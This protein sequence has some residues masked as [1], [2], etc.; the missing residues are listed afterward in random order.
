MA[1]NYVYV[2]VIFTLQKDYD[3][4]K[5]QHESSLK[6]AEVKLRT[7]LQQLR[8]ELDKNW[9]NQIK[10]EENLLTYVCLVS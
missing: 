3:C 5:T 1:R 4:L 8:T 9:K 10:Y 2:H 6:D 7:E